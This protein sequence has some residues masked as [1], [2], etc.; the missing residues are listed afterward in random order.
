MASIQWQFY[1]YGN[2]HP[3]GRFLECFCTGTSQC[4]ATSWLCIS[5]THHNSPN[6]KLWQ[7]KSKKKPGLTNG[8]LR[9]LCSA[10]KHEH[11]LDAFA[12]KKSSQ[13]RAMLPIPHPALLLQDPTSYKPF[14]SS[15]R[16]STASMGFSNTNW[17]TPCLQC[18]MNCPFTGNTGRQQVQYHHDG[19]S[20]LPSDLTTTAPGPPR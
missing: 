6:P 11:I 2:R 10:K 9:Y 4:L 17:S 20:I 1:R 13:L 16:M 14:A 8:L 12:W 3:K 5:I 19:S 15:T 7:K 18:R